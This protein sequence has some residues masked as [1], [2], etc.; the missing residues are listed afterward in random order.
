[1]ARR[2]CCKAL[3]VLVLAFA[4]AVLAAEQED[5]LAALREGQAVLVVR[6]ALAPGTGDPPGF[7]LDDCS[8]QRNLDARGRRQARAWGAFLREHGI[9]EARILSSLWCRSLETAEAMDL[10]EVTP[11]PPLNSFFGGRGDRERQT[12]ETIERVNAMPEGEPLVLV[13]H[14]VNIRAL[15]GLSVSSNGGVVMRRPLERGEGVVGRLKP[16]GR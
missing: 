5:A 15:T 2:A 6:H 10:G 14:Q 8:T 12:Q 9:G 13:S 3:L 1:M 11:F 7:E 4:P 16:A